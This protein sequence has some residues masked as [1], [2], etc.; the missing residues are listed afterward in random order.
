[1]NFQT[2]ATNVTA[3]KTEAEMLV[4]TVTF[5]QHKQT[6][7]NFVASI[8][9]LKAFFDDAQNIKALSEYDEKPDG[10]KDNCPLDILCKD[11]LTKLLAVEPLLTARAFDFLRPENQPTVEAMRN[12]MSTTQY[13]Q[14]AFNLL[15]NV[16]YPAL[17][18]KKARKHKV[19]WL[20]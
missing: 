15:N 4:D 10:I 8:T 3:L 7:D 1:M 18:P 5:Q 16:S 14:N 9:K 19:Y 20:F 2:F 13:N 17:S 12:R 11:L 6:L